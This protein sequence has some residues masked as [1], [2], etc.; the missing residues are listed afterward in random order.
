MQERDS[1]LAQK[2]L[3]ELQEPGATHFVTPYYLALIHVALGDADQAFAFLDQAI[4]MRDENVPLLKVD[5]R[6][7]NLRS[8][9]RFNDLV[10]R[11]G[12]PH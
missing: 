1:E 3:A 11:V 2:L 9:P 6:M 4:A 5:P 10:Q 8:D 12:L 7:D